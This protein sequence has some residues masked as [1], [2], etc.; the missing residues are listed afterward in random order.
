MDNEKEA[1]MKAW[2][3][4]ADALEEGD[5]ETYRDYWAHTD[6]IQAIHPKERQWLTG[7]EKVGP[8]YK[9]LIEEGDEWSSEAVLVS[10][11]VSEGGTMAWLTS[12]MTITVD[13]DMEFESWQTSIF[14]KLDGEWKLVLGHASNL[15]GE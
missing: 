2:R 7:W 12:K 8:G 1:V 13:E 6:Y 3:K 5:W 4:G 15:I 11:R 9:K 14:E 10:L